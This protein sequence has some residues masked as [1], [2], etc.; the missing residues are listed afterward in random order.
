MK[1]RNKR[2]GNVIDIKSKLSGDEWEEIK[3]SPKP[4]AGKKAGDKD[5]GIC[6]P[7]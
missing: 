4:P 6:K 7:K 2:T 3:E 1:Y 5:G